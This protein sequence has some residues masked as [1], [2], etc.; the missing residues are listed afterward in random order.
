MQLLEQL[1]YAENSTVGGIMS[2]AEECAVI[3]GYMEC[4]SELCESEILL[5]GIDIGGAIKKV[6]GMV[7]DAFKRFK[8]FCVKISKL[9]GR[10]IEEALQKFKRKKRQSNTNNSNGSQN[11]KYP[12]T[13][14]E[15]NLRLKENPYSGPTITGIDIGVSKIHRF[16]IDVCESA[17]LGLKRY[18]ELFIDI[19]T[20]N[21][22]DNDDLDDYVNKWRG[23]DRSFRDILNLDSTYSEFSNLLTSPDDIPDV[24]ETIYDCSIKQWYKTNVVYTF[25]EFESVNEASLFNVDAIYEKLNLLRSQVKNMVDLCESY[26]SKLENAMRHMALKTGQENKQ[27]KLV[28]VNQA[29]KEFTVMITVCNLTIST[30]PT[31]SQKVESDVD[32]ICKYCDLIC[33]IC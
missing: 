20:G 17:I 23:G 32:C 25:E 8:G 19:A 12:T 21:V 15:F 11:V 5:E 7:V 22:I 33:G 10:K 14:K 26:I 3:H 4:M 29:L 18:T 30:I 9:I 24:I 13:E 2:I 28:H 6:I 16:F 31:I 1:G 27:S